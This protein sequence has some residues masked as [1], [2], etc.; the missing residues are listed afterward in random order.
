M[1]CYD[2]TT[3]GQDTTIWKSGIKKSKKNLK[4]V[5]IAFKVVQVKF[6]AMQITN[7]K[8]SFDIFTII[9]LQNIFI[10]HDLYLIS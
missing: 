7:Q 9:H 10:E 6:L 4:I 2:W 8:G 1:V 3:F 5:K